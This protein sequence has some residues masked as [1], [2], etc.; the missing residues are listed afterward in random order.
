[1]LDRSK[2]LFSSFFPPKSTTT[3]TL[4]ASR[5]LPKRPLPFPIF[6]LLTQCAKR[7]SSLESG[8]SLVLISSN[9]EKG[10]KHRDNSPL[11]PLIRRRLEVCLLLFRRHRIPF[12]PARA[13]KL[14]SQI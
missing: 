8:H 14:S 4:S 10:K 7:K 6:Y 2:P 12:L 11:I 1:M 9:E 5:N 13:V 3:H